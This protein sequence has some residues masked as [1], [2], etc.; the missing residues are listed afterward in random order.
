MMRYLLFIAPAAA[1]AATLALRAAP[2]AIRTLGRSAEAKT[3]QWTEAQLARVQTGSSLVALAWTLHLSLGWVLPLQSEEDARYRAGQWIQAHAEPGSTVGM[4]TS[5]IYDWTYAPRV[6]VEA[7]LRQISLM[8]RSKNDSSGYLGLGLDWIAISDYALL[9]AR[10]ETAPQFF[11][12]LFS[13]EPYRLAHPE[14]PPYAPLS[15]P[16][17]LGFR[18]P[19]DLHYVRPTFYVFQREASS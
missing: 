4:T 3:G 8:V 7:K 5:Y 12:D 9:H 11:R 1:V 15:I 16:L 14:A 19:G 6:P 13:G 10:G 18:P 2:T 17:A